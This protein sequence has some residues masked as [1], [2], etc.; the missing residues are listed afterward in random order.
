[1]CKMFCELFG[2][3]YSLI[4]LVSPEAKAIFLVKTINTFKK[5]NLIKIIYPIQ[6]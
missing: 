2:P 3:K 4:I 6:H 1:M 5:F